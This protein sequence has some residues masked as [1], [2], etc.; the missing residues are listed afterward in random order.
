MGKTILG[1]DISS[2]T[3]GYCVLEIENN[4]I[5]FISTSYIKPIKK[6]NIVERLADTRNKI[7]KLINILKPDYI[8]IEDIVQFIRNKS[9]AKTV[10][11]LASF[12]RMISL[13]A[14][15]FLK[16]S[17]EFFSVITIRHGL[18]IK[19]TFPSKEEM[20]AIVAQHL[21]IIFPYHKN[22]KGSIKVES[23]DMADSIA[24]ALYYALVLTN[25]I[26]KVKNKPVA[27]PR[28]KKRITK[29]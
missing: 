3:I 22:K 19:N 2:T 23:Y 4:N 11:T 14:Y 26:S 18:K 1:M 7:E 10:I 25:N 27:R 17:P 24:V 9:T 6:G 13:V 21:G 8:A 15:D 16:R 20:P 12:N 5:K 28:R 29:K